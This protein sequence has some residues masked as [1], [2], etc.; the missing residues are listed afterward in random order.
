MTGCFQKERL[1]DQV[2]W[3]CISSQGKVKT[4]VSQCKWNDSMVII[5]ITIVFSHRLA[6]GYHTFPADFIPKWC[7]PNLKTYAFSCR[8]LSIP[9]WKSGMCLASCI[10]YL[11]YPKFLWNLINFYLIK[12]TAFSRMS[13][14][15]T[16]YSSEPFSSLSLPCYL[17]VVFLLTGD[18]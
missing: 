12:A 16:G 5:G 10:L 14:S 4:R 17:P 13:K 7:F 18:P 1:N 3:W 15:V 2:Q 9:K 6:N 8:R 11:G